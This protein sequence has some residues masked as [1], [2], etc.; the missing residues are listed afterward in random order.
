[1]TSRWMWVPLIAMLGVIVGCSSTAILHERDPLLVSAAPPAPPPPPPEP[2]R[3]EVKREKIQVNEKIHF[4]FDSD[5]IREE[6]FDLLDE[7]SRVINAHPQI[8]KLRVEG[9]TDP[10]GSREYNLDLS[11]RRARS[12]MTYLVEK[13]DVDPER[14]EKEG[15]GFDQPI[16]SN[17]DEE[18]MAKNRRVEFTILERDESKAPA[19]EAK[20]ADTGEQG[21]DADEETAGGEVA[22]QAKGGNQ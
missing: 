20:P 4:E 16:A 12:V 3:V 9:H 10:R 21:G 19:A 15:Y 1:M 13:G 17:D 14:L 8:V 7:I 2:E 22:E 6:S 5:K 18:G 11:K